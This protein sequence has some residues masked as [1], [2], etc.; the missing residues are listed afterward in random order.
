MANQQPACSVQDCR[1]GVSV[2][3]T[4]SRVMRSAPL[5]LILQAGEP[6][7]GPFSHCNVAPSEMFLFPLGRCS[8]AAA[9][10]APAEGSDA[11]PCNVS[12]GAALHD[13]RGPGRGIDWWE[14]APHPPTLGETDA[15][16][17]PAHGS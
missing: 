13:E 15:Y 3:R 11:L 14:P 8:L 12:R 7:S 4:L 17:P 10:G 5:E 6:S 16:P 9:S 2:A 1:T